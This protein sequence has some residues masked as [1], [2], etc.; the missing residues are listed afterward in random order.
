MLRIAGAVE[1]ASEHPVARAIAAHAQDAVGTLPLVSDFASHGGL[2]VVGVVDGRAV[3][4]GRPS[5][6][7]E[8]A[9]HAPDVL[10]P[11][12]AAGRAH[13][14]DRCGGRLGR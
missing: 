4:V 13:R 11:D 9:L 12:L 1:H 14:A 3:V 5:W 2:G 10:E 7:P 8:W 6:L